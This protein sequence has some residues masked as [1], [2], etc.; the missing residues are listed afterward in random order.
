MFMYSFYIFKYVKTRGLLTVRNMQWKE[1]YQNNTC[2]LLYNFFHKL[3]YLTYIRSFQ[4]VFKLGFILIWR[5]VSHIYYKHLWKPLLYILFRILN[6]NV[7][8]NILRCRF[9]STL[10]GSMIV[11][12]YKNF[13]YIYLNFYNLQTWC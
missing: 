4:I 5:L 13:F 6:Q 10:F 9:Q 11:L 3:Y 8:C 7:S 2:Y 12:Q 1:M